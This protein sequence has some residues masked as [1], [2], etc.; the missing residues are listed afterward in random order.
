MLKTL[1]D[2]LRQSSSA[3]ES[4]ADPAPLL[5]SLNLQ[6]LPLLSASTLVQIL[7]AENLLRSVRRLV[8]V[9]SRHWSSLYQ[10]ALDRF[11]EACQLAPASMAH[12]HAGPGGLAAHTLE[13]LE[14]ALR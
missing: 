12:H 8:A 7:E 14:I 9:D 10:P 13:S 11:L 3:T 1:R 5:A 2:K 4:R 6:Q